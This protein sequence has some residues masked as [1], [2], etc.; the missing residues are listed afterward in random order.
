MA[1]T[2][3]RVVLDAFTGEVMWDGCDIRIV[4]AGS[5]DLGSEESLRELLRDAHARA[6]LLGPQRAIIDLRALRFMNSSCICAFLD[7][8]NTASGERV[9]D[10]YPIHVLWDPKNGWERRSLDAIVRVASGRVALEPPITRSG[11]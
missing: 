2:L 7:W 5:A 3:A 4:L 6:R 10:Q 1:S 8:T 11:P 9:E